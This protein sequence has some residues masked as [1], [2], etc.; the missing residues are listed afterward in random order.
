MASPASIA[1]RN[2]DNKTLITAAQYSCLVRAW[3]TA[4]GKQLRLSDQFF[5]WTPE[6]CSEL[7]VRPDG[8]VAVSRYLHRLEGQFTSTGVPKLEQGLQLYNLRTGKVQARFDMTEN[9]GDWFPIEFQWS[10]DN[11]YL[12]ALMHSNENS[13]GN[14]K[15]VTFTS[16]ELHFLS[17]T[18][19]ISKYETAAD[20]K[21]SITR[22]W[23]SDQTRLA[24]TTE[25][26]LIILAPN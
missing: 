13:D 17:E 12:L 22:A 3:D 26:G 25:D 8:E 11:K 9:W 16:G 5:E 15:V 14:R 19:P 7:S 24:Q 2:D 18:K 23:N 4:T 10:A 1:W 20:R 6:D 21:V